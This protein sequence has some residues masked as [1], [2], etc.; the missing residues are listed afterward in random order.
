MPPQ[1]PEA[2]AS[3][4]TNEERLAALFESCYPRLTH[5]AY[6]RLGN[7]AEAE[8]VA[9]EVFVRA[10]ESLDS[11]RDRG[12][13]M[14]AW[15]FAIARNMVIDRYRKF[16]RIERV[17]DDEGIEPAGGDD[18]AGR[19]EQRVLMRDVQAALQRLTP[20]QREV[21][22]LR[23]F[24]GLSSKEVAALMNRRDGAIREMQRA[25]L[26]RLRGLLSPDHMP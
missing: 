23:F 13:P 21:V 22:S 1:K 24:G 15:L 26:E 5:Y 20:D 3:D 10:F 16:S 14:E 4:L 25:A 2:H 19:A 8:D 11:Y 12:A 9:S 6:A 17:T 18:P 7:A